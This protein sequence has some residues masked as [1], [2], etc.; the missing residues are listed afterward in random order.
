MDIKAEAKE[1]QVGMGGSRSSNR[2]TPVFITHEAII[3]GQWQKDYP[4]G[5]QG[6]RG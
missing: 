2:Q 5:N 3:H 6:N 4:M 1:S